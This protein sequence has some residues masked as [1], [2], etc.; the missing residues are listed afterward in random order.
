MTMYEEL[1]ASAREELDE[2]SRQTQIFENLFTWGDFQ[3]RCYTY[4]YWNNL[5]KTAPPVETL[6]REIPELGRMCRKCA[7]F[8]IPARGKSVPRYDLVLG[9][10]LEAALLKFLRE[11]LGVETG[12]ADTEDPRMPDCKVIKR[13]GSAAAYFEVKFHAAPFVN[14]YR[15]T[16]RYCYEGSV[17][18]DYK[19][20]G[21]QLQL[22]DQGLDAPVYYVHWLEYPCLKGVFYERSEQVRARIQ[23]NSAAF[24]RKRR[25]GDNMKMRE[26]VYL[27]KIYSPLLEMGNLEGFLQEL[28]RLIEG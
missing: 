7:D 2:F 22:I 14:C 13:D 10:H 3:Q 26:N 18:L 23:R 24:A 20:V 16:G 9:Q 6:R 11:K 19:K 12:R 28:E 4:M 8:Y 1:L 15:F 5:R 27:E 17:T 25:E 21:R